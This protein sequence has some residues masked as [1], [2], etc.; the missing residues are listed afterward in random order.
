M[1]DI[2]QKQSEQGDFIIFG[3]KEYSGDE[4]DAEIKQASYVSDKVKKLIISKNTISAEK[5][6]NQIDGFIEKILSSLSNATIQEG[7]Y[8]LKTVEIN[9]Q[10]STEGQIGFM[11]THASLSG[12]GGIKFVFS[13]SDMQS[14]Q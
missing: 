3:V 2:S 8:E 1:S 9:A 5:L 11:G 13:K 10:I 4:N 7:E 6:Q 14:R 12:S